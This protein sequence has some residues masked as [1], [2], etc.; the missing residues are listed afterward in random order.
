MDFTNKNKR[1]VLGGNRQENMFFFIQRC[2][3]PKNLPWNHCWKLWF[4]H[5]AGNQQLIVDTMYQHFSL[6]Y[7]VIC[8]LYSL[9]SHFSSF[10]SSNVGLTSNIN[11]FQLP[12][13]FL[14]QTNI[15]LNIPHLL[16]F[17]PWPSCHGIGEKDTD[18]QKVRQFLH[19]CSWE[20][21][22]LLA[23]SW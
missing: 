16:M 1:A 20:N 14:S 2:A 17:T 12:I 4:L 9:N 13:G 19:L 11:N 23:N 10:L 3:C 21:L 5:M 8:P 18:A 7:D 22:S 15:E 6:L